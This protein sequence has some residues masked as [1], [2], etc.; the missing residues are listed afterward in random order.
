MVAVGARKT[1]GA[2]GL[3]TNVDANVADIASPKVLR[4]EVI[5]NGGRECG[6][7]SLLPQQH[8]RGRV[9][10]C[11]FDEMFVILRGLIALPQI[12]PSMGG[13]QFSGDAKKLI[14]WL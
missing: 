8:H 9:T 1:K 12:V 5:D 6:H 3:K 13:S 10:F 4:A 2:V 14:V 11:F 7:F